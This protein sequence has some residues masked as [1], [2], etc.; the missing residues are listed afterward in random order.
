MGI[1]YRKLRGLTQE[2]FDEI[3]SIFAQFDR[4]HSG[5]ISKRELKACMYSLGEERS[6]QELRG[7][8]TQYG[9][10]K[11]ITFVNFRELMIHILGDTDTKASIIESFKMLARGFDV[12]SEGE[13]RLHME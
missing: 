2:Q 8:M 12:I 4:D 9:D 6:K 13:L 10:G 7:F 1:Q 5:C 11:S 3:E